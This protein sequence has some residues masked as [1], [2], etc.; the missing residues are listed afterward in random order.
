[1]DLYLQCLLSNIQPC[2]AWLKVRVTVCV[3]CISHTW[4]EVLKEDVGACQL[5]RHLFC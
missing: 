5:L 3:R 2:V 4:M 1:M